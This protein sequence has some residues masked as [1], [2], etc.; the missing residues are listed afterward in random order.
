MAEMAEMADMAV[1]TDGRDGLFSCTT[2]FLIATLAE[3][4]DLTVFIDFTRF[5]IATL[6][7]MADMT[8]FRDFS[9]TNPI[10]LRTQVPILGQA[11]S[12]CWAVFIELYH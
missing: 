2:R 6:A 9:S 8:V 1:V 10:L 11:L 5:L 12:E 3:M 7:A 4:A